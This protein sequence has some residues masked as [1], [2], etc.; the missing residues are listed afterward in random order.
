MKKSKKIFLRVLPVLIVLMV[1]FTTNVFAVTSR[2]SSREQGAGFSNFNSD[3]KV[4]ANT[5]GKTVGMVNNVWG[6]ILTILQVAAIAAIVFSGVRYMFASADSKAD[7]K[8]QMVWLVVGAVLVFAAST[9]IKLITTV[10][11][12]VTTTN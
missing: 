2:P 4:K 11:N 10:A 12:D 5:G 1:V 9:V 6:I 3:M 7:I 8:K